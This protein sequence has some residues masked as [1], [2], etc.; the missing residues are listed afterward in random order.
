M[1]MDAT[2]SAWRRCRAIPE[3]WQARAASSAAK[4]TISR[5]VGSPRHVL[6][7]RPS[8]RIARWA[9]SHILQGQLAHQRIGVAAAAASR[10]AAVGRPAVGIH[11]DGDGDAAALNPALRE[12]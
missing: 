2:H 4:S 12:A 9:E 3:L 11:T 10:D 7:D 8:L 6:T 1:C 5:P